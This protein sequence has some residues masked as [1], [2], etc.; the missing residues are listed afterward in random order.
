MY[1]E[2]RFNIK[3]WNALAFVFGS[4]GKTDGLNQKDA[5]FNK[6][7]DDFESR[8]LGFAFSMADSEG[9]YIAQVCS[10]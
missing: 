6:L 2:L 10:H 5:L 4:S 1:P 3:M 8:G 9:S 7:V